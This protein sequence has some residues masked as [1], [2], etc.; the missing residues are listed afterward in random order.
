MGTG[1]TGVRIAEGR[2]SYKNT[3]GQERTVSAD[4]VI[5]AKGASE[6][7]QLKEELHTAG[8]RVHA[9]GDCEGVAYIE[10]AIQAAAELAV[11]L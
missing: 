7:S 4:H 11:T 10:G 3:L 9:I 1:T 6:N 8:L 2:V 5:V